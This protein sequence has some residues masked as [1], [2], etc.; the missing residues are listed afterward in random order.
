LRR[1]TTLPLILPAK[2]AAVF[3]KQNILGE[4]IAWALPCISGRGRRIPPNLFGALVSTNEEPRKLTFVARKGAKPVAQTIELD[5]MTL[6]REPKFL[7]ENLVIFP[8]EGRGAKYLFLFPRSRAAEVE[9]IVERLRENLT[10]TVAPT[11]ESVVIS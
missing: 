10:G 1:E 8:T 4:T 2:L 9:T 11:R 3:S 5:G 7:S 6:S